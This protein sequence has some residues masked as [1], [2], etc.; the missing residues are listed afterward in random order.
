MFLANLT[1]LQ[2]SIQ[3]T[4]LPLNKVVK[5]PL[6]LCAN[7]SNLVETDEVGASIN[8]SFRE[9]DYTVQGSTDNK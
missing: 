8:T 2:F 3:D 4:L 1:V 6:S 7:Y 9:V 5:R